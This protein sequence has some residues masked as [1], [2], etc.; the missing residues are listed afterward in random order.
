MSTFSTPG[1]A[2]ILQVL[3]AMIAGWINRHQQQV[4]AY[5]LEENC[6]LLR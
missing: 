5:L 4:I 3:I 2:M 1:V 6:T